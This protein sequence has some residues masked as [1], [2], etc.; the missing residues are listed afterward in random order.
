MQG[1]KA[2]DNLFLAILF[3]KLNGLIDGH[4]EYVVDVFAFKSDFQHFV[5]EPLSVT[6]FALQFQIGH[7]LHFHFH[8]ACAFALF[9]AS[10]FGIEGEE[11]R[12]HFHLFGQ[13]LFGHKFAN[14][15]VGLDIGDGVG[16]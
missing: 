2:I 14:L 12:F 3:K 1:T 13:G 8:R 15:I 7:K 6:G 9:A 16:A 5:L 10:A 11:S 4:L